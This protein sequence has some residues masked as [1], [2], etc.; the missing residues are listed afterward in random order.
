MTFG[1]FALAFAIIVVSCT[2][3]SSIGFGSN[4]VAMP[5]IVHFGPDLVPGSVLVAVTA[6]NL[7]MLRRDRIGLEVRPVGNALVGR[8]LGTVI[9]LV[10]LEALSDR[11]LQL[12]IGV[13]VLAMVTVAASGFA[14][15]R[16][17]A[18]M[19]TAGTISG[20]TAATAGIGGPPV[21]L[22]FQRAS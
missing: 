10:V 3:Q 2:V 4:L 21:A 16:S 8:A 5:T 13:A 1:L 15:V 12:V 9:A 22:L 14:P 19:L 17:A 6:M 7:L 11:G 20:F 18:T